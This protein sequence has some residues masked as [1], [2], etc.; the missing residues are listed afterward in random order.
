[1]S[2][3]RINSTKTPDY[4]ITPK[5]NYYGTKTRV[6]FNGSCLKQDSVTFNHG[7]VVNIYIVYEISKSFNISDYVTLKNCLFGTVS[8]I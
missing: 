4:G 6:E 8:L 5:L 2:D 1:M 3:K 7:K